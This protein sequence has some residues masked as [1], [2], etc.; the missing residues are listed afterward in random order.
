MVCS[1]LHGLLIKSKWPFNVPPLQPCGFAITRFVTA[2]RMDTEAERFRLH[3]GQSAEGYLPL[4]RASHHRM[5]RLGQRG[6]TEWQAAP[7][8]GTR[9]AI[10]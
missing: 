5:L 10:A 1:S 3:K 4:K 7:Y 9:V 2:S 8:R 6:T